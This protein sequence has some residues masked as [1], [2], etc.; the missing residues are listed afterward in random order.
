VPAEREITFRDLL[1]HTSGLDYP[2]IGTKNMKAIYAKENIPSG[3]GYFDANLQNRMKALGKLPLVHQPGEKFTYGL[4]SD[5]L[6]SLIEII[7]GKNLEDYL[8]E[9]I[10]QPLGMKD[11]WFNLPKNLWPRLASVYT[12]DSLHHII[13]WDHHFRHIDPDYPMMN[14]HYFS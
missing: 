5:L 14:K 9:N 10:F 2:D 6:G 7:S 8:H 13:K 1:T 12:E 11:T 3:L 4:N